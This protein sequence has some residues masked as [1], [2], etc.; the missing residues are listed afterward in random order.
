MVKCALLVMLVTASTVVASAETAPQGNTLHCRLAET[1]RTRVSL[2][3][4]RFTAT[5]SEPVALNG[6]DVSIVATQDFQIMYTDVDTVLRQ[7]YDNPRADA[8][9]SMRFVSL[10]RSAE[11]WHITCSSQACGGTSNGTGPN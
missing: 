4:D 6:H 2:Q 11:N 1:L 3:G 5:V 9:L 8:V 7:Q 10:S